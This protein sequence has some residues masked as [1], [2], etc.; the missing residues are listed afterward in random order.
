VFEARDLAPGKYVVTATVIERAGGRR[1]LRRNFE[2]TGAD[3][4]LSMAMLPPTEVAG[5][6]TGLPDASAATIRFDVPREDLQVAG[7]WGGH[8][9]KDGQFRVSLAPDVYV[10]HATVPDGYYLKAVRHRGEELTGQT[11]DLTGPSAP[12]EFVV[13]DDGGEIAGVVLDGEDR[14]VRTAQV[15]LEPVAADWPDRLRLLA[16]DTNGNFRIH[17]VAPGEYRLFAWI[18][19]EP[20]EARAVS[21]RVE[22]NG[23][24]RVT[25]RVP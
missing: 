4:E 7:A 15:A 8:P 20:D 11:V 24:H 9:G 17:D 16:T 5:S 10:A 19:D 12:V 25:L 2:I 14:T 21:L 3:V 18:R 13:S 6:V 23:D 22:A 1:D